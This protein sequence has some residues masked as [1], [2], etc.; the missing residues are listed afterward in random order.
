MKAVIID[1]TASELVLVAVNGEV[2]K[3]HLGTAGARRH[4]GEILTALDKLLSLTNME[5]SELD[6]VGVVV[7]PGSFTGI[8]IG[9]STANAMA[10][11]SGAKL[12]ELTELESLLINEERALG[13]I[14]CKHDNYYALY[15]EGASKEYK[16]VNV[17]DIQP[18]EGKK[19]YFDTPNP[20]N[21]YK[22]FLLKVENNEFSTVAKPYYMKKS[23]AE[24]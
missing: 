7:G 17:V 1:S 3:S 5:A 23:S 9:V 2:V 14:D 20:Q 19:V 6:Y 16:A 21:L 15:K 18:Y 11:A 10:Y 24:A 8:R 13:L 4:T 22:T 12:V